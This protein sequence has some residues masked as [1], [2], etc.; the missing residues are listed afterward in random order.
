MGKRERRRRR[1]AAA[2]AASPPVAPRAVLTTDTLR[3][4][5]ARRDQLERTITC[6]IDRLAD[7]GVGWPRIAAALGVSRQAARQAALRRG[8]S[9]SDPI[10]IR[11]T[12]SFGRWSEGARVTGS[13]D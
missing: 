6:E 8:T 1:E 2:L 12:G 3:R 13:R 10:S 7:A 9:A 5:V 4:L 11:S